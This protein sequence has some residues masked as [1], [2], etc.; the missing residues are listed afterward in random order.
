MKI[1]MDAHDELMKRI[2]TGDNVDQTVDKS[3]KWILAR[4]CDPEM[5]RRSVEILPPMLGNPKMV[6]VTNDD[7]FILK[8]KARKWSVIFFA[9]GACR[10]DAASM[11]I[12]GS[13]KQTEGWGLEQYRN[14]VKQYQG[15]DVKIVETKDEQEI[16]PL[17]KEA[18]K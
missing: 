1:I 3:D 5:G 12:P 2:I 13:R 14:L 17:L 8:L 10:Y 7:D 15:D 11:P 18:L 16:I 9:P 4:G 6:S